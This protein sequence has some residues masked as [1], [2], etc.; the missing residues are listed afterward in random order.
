M[1]IYIAIS[2]VRKA[3]DILL[4]KIM[5]PTLFRCGAHP[6]PTALLN[7]LRNVTG[8]PDPETCKTLTKQ[9]DKYFK[10]DD[11]SF[12]CSTC[13]RPQSR[14]HFCDPMLKEP[15]STDYS[16]AVYACILCPGNL[17][18][19]N[20]SEDHKEILF[21][22]RKCNIMLPAAMYDYYQYPDRL[23]RK[24]SC[25]DCVPPKTD[26]TFQCTVC[27]KI[28][29]QTAYKQSQWYHRQDQNAT[30]NSCLHPTST[31]P[32]CKACKTCYNTKCK[33]KH[34]TKECKL[35]LELPRNLSELQQWKCPTCQFTCCQ[36]CGQEPSNP[37]RTSKRLEARVRWTCA[38]CQQKALLEENKQHQ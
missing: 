8:R 16:E 35:K 12:F 36:I 27:R 32:K 29:P 21:Q 10:I 25:I 6:W 24:D 31:N 7:V 14:R 37:K 23:K 15:K 1:K 20:K 3:H 9:N 38:E 28:L 4:D 19:C 33:A 26:S 5:S 30:C 17:R 13:Q 11:L 34:C 2:R 22:C 18:T